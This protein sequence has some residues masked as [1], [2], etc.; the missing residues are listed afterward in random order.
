[1][2]YASD[3]PRAVGPSV[4]DRAGASGTSAHQDTLNVG[5]LLFAFGV[6]WVV[7]IAAAMALAPGSLPNCQLTVSGDTAMCLPSTPAAA[8]GLNVSAIVIPAGLAGSN[9]DAF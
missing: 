5:Y 7:A 2:T 4:L 3:F 1:M 8:A 6:L 9:Y